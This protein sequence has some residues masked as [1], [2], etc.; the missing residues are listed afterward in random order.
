MSL[1]QNAAIDVASVIRP[2]IQKVATGPELSEDLNREE[3]QAAMELIMQGKV[4]PVQS[5][6]LLIALRMK[7]EAMDEYRGILQA[8]RD[9]TATATADVDELMDVADPYDGYARGLP[10]TPFL[11]AVLAACGLP[12]VSH[13]VE[14]MGPKY[15]ATHRMILREA[16]ARVDLSPAEAAERIAHPDIGWAYVDMEAFCPGLHNLTAL[17]SQIVKR[18]CL[19]TVENIVGPV[20]ARNRTHLLI[21]YVHKAYPPIYSELARFSGFDSGLVVRGVEGGVTPSLQQ[22]GR[23][24]QYKDKGPEQE[25][26]IEPADLGIQADGRAVPLPEDLTPGKLKGKNQETVDSA[27]LARAA[28]AAGLAALEGAAGPTR[29]SLAYSGALCLWHLGREPDLKSAADRI[30]RSLDDGSARARFLA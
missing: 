6:V 27:A 20:R 30:R 9:N 11:P 8:I 26:L 25:V 29:E 21:G 13:G 18:T 17:R 19:T 7:R 16:G 22:T 4:D 28:A 23:L 2:C 10:A 14:A 15:G 5:A 3:A 12:A 24:F 1:S